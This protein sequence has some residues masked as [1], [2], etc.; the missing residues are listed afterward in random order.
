M[1]ASLAGQDIIVFDGE[2]VLC[3]GFFRF[4]LRHDR[5]ERFRFVIA[6]SPLGTRI[7]E[8]LGLPTRDY[9]TNLVI[10]DGQIN[11]KGRAFAQAMRAIGRP[12]AIL[13][14]L[15]FVPPAISDPIYHLIARN[16]YRWFG[17]YDTCM[18]PDATV[19]ARFLP[20]GWA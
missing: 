16:R 2:C 4:M 12:W 7:Y 10:V 13:G 18:I 20:E 17:R 9:E 5:S 6:Q 14:P 8:A 11:R 15:R 1:R 3:S 19:R